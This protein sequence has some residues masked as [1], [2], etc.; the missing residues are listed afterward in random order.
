MPMVSLRQ[1]LDHAAENGYGVPAFNINNM[2]QLIAIMQAAEKTD[3][4]PGLGGLHLPDRAGRVRKRQICGD[5]E[6]LFG[7]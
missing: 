6:F 4:P 1:L 5:T 2:E 3:S 7:R